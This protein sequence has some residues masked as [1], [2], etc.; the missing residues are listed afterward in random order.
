LRRKQLAGST[1][2][3]KLRWADFTTPTRQMTL[4]HPTDNSE[5]IYAAAEQLFDRL[6]QTGAPIRLLGVGVSGLG[7]AVVQPE[8]WDL[9]DERSERISSILA[10]LRTKYGDNVIVR[11][12]DMGEASGEVL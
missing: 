7:P 5:R 9:P 10:E 6:W 2:K 3:L 4:A 8:L 11:G 1:V 12:S